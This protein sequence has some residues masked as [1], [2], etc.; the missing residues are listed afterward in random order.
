MESY[1]F[2]V[3]KLTDAYTQYNQAVQSGNSSQ[4]DSASLNV[5]AAGVA[6]LGALGSLL[7]VIPAIGEA[8][9]VFPMLPVGL[10][11][12]GAAVIMGG[13]LLTGKYLGGG[14]LLNKIFHEINGWT[15][16]C[17]SARRDGSGASH[18]SMLEA[19]RHVVN[20]P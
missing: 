20:D 1:A 16:S 12:G 4:I 9:L 18:A 3:S 14:D 10:T 15:I 19:V 5:A 13:L 6:T 11:L 17:S 2:N 8:G 7:S